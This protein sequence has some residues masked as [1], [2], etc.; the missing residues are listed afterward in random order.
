MWS[1]VEQKDGRSQPDV[2]R[3]IVV[4]CLLFGDMLSGEEEVD[5]GPCSYLERCLL[6][7]PDH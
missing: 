2:H 6:H 7:Q 1:A 3:R 4:I 5:H